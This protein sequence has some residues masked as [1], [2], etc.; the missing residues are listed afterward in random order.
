MRMGRVLPRQ[1][2]RYLV[3]IRDATAYID[4]HCTEALTLSDILR[5]AHL[6][7]TTFLASFRAV[8]NMTTWDY[9]HIR[10]V[11]KALSLLRGTD[12]GILEIAL[13][14]GFNST[15]GFH[16]VFKK[17]TGI[18]PNAYRQSRAKK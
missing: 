15:T 8:Y 10:R 14:C 13:Q 12:D 7:K 3:H 6:N 9:I 17:V 2:L 4:R 5:A 18:T 1:E 11:E 16:K